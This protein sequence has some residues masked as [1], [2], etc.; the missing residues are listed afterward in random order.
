MKRLFLTAAAFPALKAVHYGTLYMTAAAFAG[1]MSS[2]SDADEDADL[3][4]VSDALSSLDAEFR[5]HSIRIFLGP[6]DDGRHSFVDL[7]YMDYYGPLRQTLNVWTT[8]VDDDDF[9]DKIASTAFY[10]LGPY[11]GTEMLVGPT[12]EWAR[13]K[14]S[15]GNPVHH[16]DADGATK[17]LSLAR[18][19][20]E[21]LTPGIVTQPIRAAQAAAGRTLPSGR[22]LRLQDELAA[23]VGLPGLRPRPDAHDERHRPAL[24]SQDRMAK[25][26]VRPH[27]HPSGLRRRRHPESLP[28]RLGRHPRRTPHGACGRRTGTDARPEPKAAVRA[29]DRRRNEPG[30]VRGGDQ[31]HLPPHLAP[32]RNV[33]TPNPPAAHA[34]PANPEGGRE[35]AHQAPGRP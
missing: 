12:W 8:D 10:L 14:D 26:P 25:V 6:D 29:A 34:R 33:R 20:V 4:E 13:N 7:S 17:A 9:A 28:H 31:R 22:D 35:R 3:Q 30:D 32:H 16:P 15:W 1:A 24:R 19:M 18:H 23:M 27:L 21:R 5:E 11:W 2:D